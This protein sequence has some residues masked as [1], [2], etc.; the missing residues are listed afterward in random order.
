MRGQIIRKGDRIWQ[1]YGAANHD[2]DYFEDPERFDVTRKNAD[3]HVSFGGGGPH[4]CIGWPLARIEAQVG[5][6]VLLEKLPHMT[7]ERAEHE[8]QTC[9]A[10]RNRY[11]AGSPRYKP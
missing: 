4:L 1:V 2:E 7:L 10:R 5:W 8:P 11:L 6:Q 9:H 3:Q